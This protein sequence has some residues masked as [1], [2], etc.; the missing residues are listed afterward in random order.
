M[1]CDEVVAFVKA[2]LA[3]S[4]DKKTL[5]RV[6]SWLWLAIEKKRSLVFTFWL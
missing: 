3:I 2:F 6:N 5:L 1:S 4:C